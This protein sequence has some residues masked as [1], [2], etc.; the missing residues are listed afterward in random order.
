MRIY[1]IAEQMITGLGCTVDEN[2]TALSHGTSGLAVHQIPALDNSAFVLSSVDRSA[3]DTL[4][5]PMDVP[6]AFTH[7]ERMLA[8][9]MTLAIE[10]CAISPE[11][12]NV[13]VVIASTKGNI[14]LLDSAAPY[15]PDHPIHLTSTAARMQRHFNFAQIPVVLSHACT[16]GLMAVI[17]ACRLLKTGR[18]RYAIVSG[19]DIIAPFTI[20]GFQALGAIDAQP[21][22]PY[23][24]SRAGINLGEGCG[25]MILAAES[26]SADIAITGTGNSNDANH[27]SGPSR[28]GAGLIQAVRSA[29]NEADAVNVDH[30]SAHGTATLFNDEMEAQAFHTLGMQDVPLMSA[31]GYWGHTLGA[32]GIVELIALINS[33]RTGQLFA[34]MGYR[35]NGLT[36]PLNVVT[37]TQAAELNCCL[38]TSSGF[39]GSNSAVILE[40][41]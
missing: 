40:R 25:T 28:T 38:K 32:A 16:S 10:N 15:S 20:S 35:D 23:D 29:M 1:S 34:S 37:H 19:V 11:D 41:T 18:Y 3:L 5:S 9:S 39:G 30:I 21:C 26:G 8:T 14:D 12:P 24:R 27:I 36:L 7:L 33:M 2:I 4:V 6:A 22:R 31:K 13:L 17:M